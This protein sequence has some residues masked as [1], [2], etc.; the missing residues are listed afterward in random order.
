MRLP[1]HSEWHVYQCKVI[2]SYLYFFHQMKVVAVYVLFNC[3]IQK[4]RGHADAHI[5]KTDVIV[6][7]HPFD[8]HCLLL[9]EPDNTKLE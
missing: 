9:A 2:H 5:E 4:K 6:V 7:S 1:L 8:T 3:R